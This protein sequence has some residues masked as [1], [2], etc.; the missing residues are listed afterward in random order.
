MSLTPWQP[1]PPPSRRDFKQPILALLLLVVVAGGLWALGLVYEQQAGRRPEQAS[2]TTQASRPT[3]PVQ[4]TAQPTEPQRAPGLGGPQ[5]PAATDSP[6]PPSPI[7]EEDTPTATHTPTHTPTPA[8]PALAS[9]Q[10]LDASTVPARDPYALAARLKFKDG[11]QIER[12]S[13]NP[14]G[15]YQVGRKDVFNV[16]DIQ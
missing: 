8:D 3:P 14:P 2:P 11:R 7:R 16:S 5:P 4:P 15:N 13:A 12:T 1:E 10:T 9:L 6:V